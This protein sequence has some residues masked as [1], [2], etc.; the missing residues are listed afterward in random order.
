MLGLSLPGVGGSCSSGSGGD[1]AADD[2]DAGLRQ[3]DELAGKLAAAETRIMG[4]LSASLPRVDVQLPKLSPTAFGP[5]KP[6]PGPS[7]A[8]AGYFQRLPAQDALPTL[9]DERQGGV[10]DDTSKAVRAAQSGASQRAADAASRAAAAERQADLAAD[11][12]REQASRLAAEAQVRARRRFVVPVLAAVASVTLSVGLAFADLGPLLGPAAAAVTAAVINSCGLAFAWRGR[13]EMVFGIV[14]SVFGG[15]TGRVVQVLDTVDD[16]VSAPLQRL[17][18]AIDDMADEQKPAFEL[19]QKFESA[20][21]ALDPEFDIP[22]PQDLKQSLDG[23]EDMIEELVAKAKRE[24]PE[25]LHELAGATA[26]GRVATDATLFNRVAVLLP[27][28]LV[29]LVNIALAL[30]QV[31]LTA[32][33]SSG[34]TASQ[35]DR[36][37][38]PGASEAVARKLR[39]AR[40]P[41]AVGAAGLQ[42]LS[43]QAELRPYVEPALAQVALALLQQMVAIALSQGPRICGAVN[44]AI[45][46]LEK[47]VNAKVNAR[48]EGAVDRVFGR[49]FGEVKALSERFFPKF[50]DCLGKLKEALETAQKAQAAVQAAQEAAASAQGAGKALQGLW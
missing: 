28:A 47:Q 22:D 14:S 12:M 43:P 45:S 19:V 34:P 25:Q 46:A 8:A 38:G 15:V 2:I 9:L 27:V 20:L 36:S 37:D 32:Q 18:G 21:K 39:G 49:A 10:L 30:L 3:V 4:M 31:F 41:A 24:V 5:S 13:A 1:G 17:L 16:M 35:T 11:E 33:L 6:G 40:D 23:C 50:K 26:V 48:V 7:N 29:F 42:G 44:G